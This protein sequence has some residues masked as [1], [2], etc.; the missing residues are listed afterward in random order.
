[1]YISGQL[2]DS[3][4]PALEVDRYLADEAIISCH[5]FMYLHAVSAV[6]IL[7]LHGTTISKYFKTK[8]LLRFD[9]SYST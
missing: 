2:W 7:K 1:M 3:V 4:M 9:P 5:G 6:S 8:G